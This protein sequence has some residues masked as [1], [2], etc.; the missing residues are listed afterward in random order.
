MLPKISIIT[1]TFNAEKH[2]ER[3]IKSII[4]QTYKNIE[5]II[6][7]G[8]SKDATIK[9]IKNYK[10]YIHYWL[11]EPDT[12]LYNAM[13][14]GIKK[15][16][17]DYLLFMNAGDQLYS[18]E[19]LQN[20]LQSDSELQDIYYGETTITDENEKIIG[21]RRLSAPKKLSW[22]S[23]KKGMRVSHQSFIPKRKITP[24]YDETYKFSADFDWCIKILKKASKI[25]NTNLIITRYLDGGLTKQ[26]LI[27]SLKERFHIMKKFYGIVPTL[28]N[29]VLL[30]MQL[31]LFIIKNKWF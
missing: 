29:H 17:G 26:N 14:K 21:K 12:G 13:N 16:T 18:Q 23:F 28:L 25:K 4:E 2:I 19:T 9:I 27:P 24:M 30:G 11:S 3:T 22:K 1:I 15:A 8:C 7:D 10:K 6:I 5:Y 31:S 20:I